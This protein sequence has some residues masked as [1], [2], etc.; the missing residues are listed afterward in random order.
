MKRSVGYIVKSGFAVFLASSA[1]LA[2]A[3]EP[4]L[5]ILSISVEQND[6]YRELE[7][8]FQEEYPQWTIQFETL[9]QDAFN[10]SLPLSFESGNAPDLILHDLGAPLSELLE[11]GW[12][13]PL[14][15]GEDVPQEWFDRFPP[16]SFVEGHNMMDGV[17]FGVPLNEQDIQGYG[18]MYYNNEV[19]NA[20]GVDP[21][22][23]I[24]TTW[25]ELLEVCERVKAGG[26]S[27][28][29]ASFNEPDQTIRWWLPFT[30]VAETQ[31]PMN[32]RT[33]N[34][35]YADPARLRAWQ[36]LKTLYDN[37]HFIP[38]VE[39]TD[40]DTS[41]QIFA[42]GQAAFYMDGSWM[43]S[44]FRTGMGFEDLDYGVAAVPVPDDGVQG[45]LSKSLMPS[46]LY[47]TSQV[48][49]PEAAWAFVD[50]LTRPEGPY[51]QGFVGGGFG[52]LSFTDNSLWVDP[53]DEVLQTLVSIGQDG[54]RVFEPVPLLA[55][56]DMAQSTALQDALEATSVPNEVESVVEALV[57]N[58]DWAQEAEQHAEERQNVFE[59]NLEDERA[60][61]LN[62]SADY[63]T[64]P[65]WEFDT[66]FDY[67]VYPLCEQ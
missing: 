28:F 2:A 60:E 51:A 22:T 25:S 6:L 29:S 46:R 16:N 10:Q 49:D 57:T 31:S 35:S 3:Q 26:F 30:A 17:P 43:P 45:K 58:Q 1:M 67:S 11:N 13:S 39:S 24:P 7:Q 38:G 48:S 40:R 52:F 8:A 65:N 20:S 12:L 54:Y 33:G 50:W 9:S 47:V 19:L 53:E 27:C 41:R 18:Y 44:V 4:T 55:C 34:F 63:Y 64:Y 66:N 23:E 14:A 5:R 61:G 32:Y 56:A 36:L 62:V 59:A 21:S 15:S 42:L 37:E